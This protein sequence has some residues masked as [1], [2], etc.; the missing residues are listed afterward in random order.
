MG[1]RIVVRSASGSG[2]T[3]FASRLAAALGL[4]HVELDALHHGPDWSEA[5]PE[6]FRR[7]VAEAT[8][9]DGWIADGNYDS[10]LG[11]LLLARADTVVWLD[12]PLAVILPRLRRRTASRIRKET[13]LWHGNREDWRNALWGRESLL[14]VA[15]RTHHRLRR[16]LPTA[17]ARAEVP[18]VRLRTEAETD[19]WLRRVTAEP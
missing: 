15:V 12:L 18:L 5:P 17:A 14:V 1:R 19:A 9:G 8:E 16:E 13:E 7:R 10:R 3:T 11:D 2:K 4:P 6:E